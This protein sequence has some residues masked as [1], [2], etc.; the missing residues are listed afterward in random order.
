MKRKTIEEVVKAIEELS[1]ADADAICN[2]LRTCKP[3]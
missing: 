1:E 2:K 3:R